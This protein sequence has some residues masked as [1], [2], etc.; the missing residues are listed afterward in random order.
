MLLWAIGA[1][2]DPV[3]PAQGMLLSV[4]CLSF[5]CL[6]LAGRLARRPWLGPA[7]LAMLVAGF[8]ASMDM[9]QFTEADRDAYRAMEYG[10]AAGL[11]K[12][13]DAGVDPDLYNEDHGFLLSAAVSSKNPAVIKVLID[14]GADVNVR[15]GNHATP[16]LWAVYI[17]RCQ[18][19]L[20]LA[21]AG[22][23][24]EAR[25]YDDKEIAALPTYRGKD[26]AEI[27]YGRKREYATSWK[28]DEACWLQFETVLKQ[29]K[30][31]AASFRCDTPWGSARKKLYQVFG[32]V[33][34]C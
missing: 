28:Q 33:T 9:G 8:A 26:V 16:L 3:T 10:D 4:S 17:P 31:A 25:F 6:S 30:E 23:N 12:L 7:G 32:K 14:A 11:R 22:A 1:Q 5:P 24:F 19:A 20:P 34:P 18:A 29:K 13:L 2:L 27:Y 21:R 15:K